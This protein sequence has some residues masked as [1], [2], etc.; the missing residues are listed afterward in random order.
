MILRNTLVRNLGII[1]LVAVGLT[2]LGQAGSQITSLLFLVLR[3]AFLIALAGLAVSIWRQ[4]RGTFGLMPARSKAMLYGGAIG[5]V[6]LVVTADLWAGSSP[7]A[8]LVFFAALAGCGYL[9]YRGW[10]ESRRYYY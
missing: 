6:L 3:I 10:Q 4:N 9:C 1:A 8:A 5:I 7:L 2:A